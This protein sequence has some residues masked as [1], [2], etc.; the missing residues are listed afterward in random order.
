VP[1]TPGDSLGRILSRRRLRVADSAAY[2]L[3]LAGTLVIPLVFWPLGND[4]F[5]EVKFTVLR[6]LVF[7]AGIA[8]AIWLFARRPDISGRPSDWMVMAFVV[9]SVVASATSIDRSTSFWGEP[10]QRAGLATTFGLVGVYAVAR[11][12]IRTWQ[13]L[14]M[15]TSTASA[16]GTLVA[17]YAFV[18]LVG[19][20][21]VWSV[22][23]GGRVFSTIGQPNWLAAY[24][25]LTFPL[26]LT[27]AGRVEGRWTRLA[28][29]AA[30]IL[31][32]VVLIFS[33]SR[34]GYIGLAVTLVVGAAFLGA[35]GLRSVVEL[36]RV[37]YVVLA[38]LLLGGIAV[39]ALSRV[40]ADMTPERL[41]DRAVSGF[42]LESFDA[43]RYLGLWEVGLWIAMDH[44]LLGAGQDTYAILFPAYRDLVLPEEMATHF[45]RFRPESPHSVYLAI[46]SGSG[47]PALVAYVAILLFTL[48]ELLPRIDSNPGGLLVLG[49]ALAV[50]GHAV[51]DAFM[52]LDLSGSW[53]LWALLGSVPS[54]LHNG[55]DCSFDTPGADDVE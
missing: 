14:H 16:A 26:T 54:A 21:P 53:L 32:V 20:D 47:F 48:R 2:A 33:L 15:L 13:R 45:S 39:T 42:Q 11:I 22:L 1:E 36:R 8:G 23:P 55:S 38:V 27:L 28:V 4:V 17:L 37:L 7:G 3:L 31:Q 46:A 49:I 9:V 25:V 43:K 12:S 5:V 40:V 52:T 6:V 30:A 51:T 24:L 10:L 41:F 50:M 29:V 35:Q 44:P 34:S 18:Q 19:A